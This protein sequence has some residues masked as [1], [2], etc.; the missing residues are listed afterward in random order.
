[1]IRAVMISLAFL[2]SLAGPTA[3]ADEF[4]LN[5]SGRLTDSIGAPVQGPVDLT[6]EFF[7]A[8]INGNQLSV[9]KTFTAVPLVDGIFQVNLQLTP[10]ER[11]TIFPGGL[12][13]WIELQDSTNQKIYP[14]QSFSAVPLA[15]RVPVD[16]TS[17]RWNSDGELEAPAS[18]ATISGVV[19]GN[20]LSGRPSTPSK[21]PSRLAPPPSISKATS[22][23]VRFKPT[24]R[25]TLTSR[26]IPRPDTTPSRSARPTA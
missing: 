11:S 5:Y 19:A 22:R 23:W 10:A 21:A 3:V 18:A 8:P 26:P 16:G 17:V 25:P 1:M 7:D 9:T 20:G 24:S 13:T 4:A 12:T 15:L 6:C 14:R 2:A